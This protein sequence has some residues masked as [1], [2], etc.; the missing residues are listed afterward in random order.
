[1]T[2]SENYIGEV[3]RRLQERGDEHGEKIANH[4]CYNTHTSQTI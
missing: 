4:I 3:A 1:M 2:L